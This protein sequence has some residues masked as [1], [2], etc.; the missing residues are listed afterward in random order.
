MQTENIRFEKKISALIH[1]HLGW[2]PNAH[3]LKAPVSGIGAGAEP[4]GISDPESPRPGISPAILTVPQWMT[5]V[6]LVI[7]FATFFVGGN[8]LWPALVLV[9]LAIFVAI[10]IQS[11]RHQGE[12]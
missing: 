6:A 3:T 12:S 4:A 2:C 11:I 8:I 9:I 5:A 1:H 10:H 7:L